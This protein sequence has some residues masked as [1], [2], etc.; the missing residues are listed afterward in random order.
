MKRILILLM[1]VFLSSCVT[2]KFPRYLKDEF[3]YKKQYDASFD[4][5]YQA[6]TQALKELGWAIKDTSYPAVFEQKALS[7]YKDSRQVLI[8]TDIRQTPLLFSTRYMGLN[9]YVWS[10]GN[11]TEVEIRYLAMTPVLFKSTQSYK[12]DAVVSKIFKRIGR[13]L[14]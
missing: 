14:Q 8:F 9:I 13:I 7:G 3:P 4:K 1:V 11:Q 12:N 5:T 6:T 10:K 2:V